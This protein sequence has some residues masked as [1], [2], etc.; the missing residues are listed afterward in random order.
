MMLQESD[1]KV[2]TEQSTMY[3]CILSNIIDSEA[4]YVEWLNV[5]LQVSVC[6]HI[7]VCLSDGVVLQ[8]MKAIKATLRTSHPVITE[9][10]FRTIFYKIPELHLLHSNF[11][12]GLR[13]HNEKGTNRIGD[14]FKNMASLKFFKTKF[15]P[16]F[17]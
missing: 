12:E 3:K 1:V 15:N 11:L 14:S 17:N 9:A 16:K 10:E 5:M 13:R 4:N 7:F 8:Y 2:E 6:T